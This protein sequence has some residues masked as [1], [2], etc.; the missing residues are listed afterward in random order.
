MKRGFF[1]TLLLK[2]VCSAGERLPFRLEGL[3]RRPRLLDNSDEFPL[4]LRA[5]MHLL[6]NPVGD[7]GPEDERP[8]AGHEL[9]IEFPFKKLK[10]II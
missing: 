10:S 9:F 3:I 1:F 5:K 4:V 7:R 6:H 8:V 2:I